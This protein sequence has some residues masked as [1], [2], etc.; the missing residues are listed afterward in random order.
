MD[1]TDKFPIEKLKELI[2]FY[3]GDLYYR[4]TTLQTHNSL[5]P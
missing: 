1:W 2:L 5:E 4:L 3:I